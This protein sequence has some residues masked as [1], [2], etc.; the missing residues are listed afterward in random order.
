MSFEIRFPFPFGPR[1]GPLLK[2]E[3]PTPSSVQKKKG[4]KRVKIE[5]KI[6]KTIFFLVGGLEVARG[7]KPGGREGP[8]LNWLSPLKCSLSQSDLP[9][10]P[11]GWQQ[12]CSHNFETTSEHTTIMALST[13]SQNRELL[14]FLPLPSTAC[15]PFLP[16]RHRQ[17]AHAP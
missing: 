9:S 15:L 8:A 14:P 10:L 7:T 6:K 16:V 1:E 2:Q 11:H 5:S 13:L 12:S 17:C 3:N 4:V